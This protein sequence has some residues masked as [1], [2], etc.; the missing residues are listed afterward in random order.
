LGLEALGLDLD[1]V[2]LEALGLD[3]DTVGLEALGLDLDTVGR[4]LTFLLRLGDRLTRTNFALQR[5]QERAHCAAIDNVLL[6]AFEEQNP[7]AARVA[8]LK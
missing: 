5:L 8:Q 7:C 4:D 6:L 1:T 2:G 3:L